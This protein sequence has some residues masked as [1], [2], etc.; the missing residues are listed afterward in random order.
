MENKETIGSKIVAL[1]KA[2]N[3]TQADL[4]MYLNVSYQA[5]S[6]WERDESCPDF[7]TLSRIA[8][9]FN[10]PISYFEKSNAETATTVAN[11]LPVG[12]SAKEMLGVCKDCGK[13]VYAGDEAL[14]TPALVCKT[15]NEERKRQ[16]KIKAERQ[17][18]EEDKKRQEE[19]YKAAQRREQ[20][21]KDRNK[22]FIWGSIATGVW[23]IL[24]VV[25]CFVKAEEWLLILGGGL[26]IS[27][28]L[29]PFI[30]Q[31]FWDGAVVTCASAASHI[32]TPGVI[33]EF[34]VDGF[35]FLIAMKILFA[36]IRLLVFLLTGLVCILA[37][38]L[39]SPFT[40]FPALARVNSGDLV[41]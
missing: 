25:A 28:F 23:L 35:I 3:F 18:R 40:F 12:N 11:S 7:D 31:L 30:A 39:I 29:F 4:G 1:R 27:V 19:A 10:V 20:I 37:A 13:V 32:G 2:R 38:M 5:V 9:F 17:K 15:C 6:K 14:T 21:R 34:S 8:Q 41:L 16:A 26:G 36:C 22:G 24:V 33:F